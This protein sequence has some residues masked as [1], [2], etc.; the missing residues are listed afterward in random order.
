MVGGWTL[1]LGRF[2][3]GGVLGEWVSG[4][5]KSHSLAFFGGFC[6]K[7]GGGGVEGLLRVVSVF[8]GGA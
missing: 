6:D 2:G 1:C 7:L 3:V 8:G 4:V 5:G